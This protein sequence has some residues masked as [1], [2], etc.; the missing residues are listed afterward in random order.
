MKR[1]RLALLI[2]T[3]VAPLIPAHAEDVIGAGDPKVAAVYALGI[4]PTASD[5]DCVQSIELKNPDGSYSAASYSGTHGF[6]QFKDNNGNQIT[7]AILDWKIDS[8]TFGIKV[9]LETPEHIILKEGETVSLRGG[10]LR[11]H[12]YTA[13]PINTFLRIKVRTSW[14]KPMDVQL[15][16]RDSNFIQTKIAGGNLW[17]M[18]GSGLRYSDYAQW[19]NDP[20]QRNYSKQADKEEVLFDIFI[21][22]A[23]SRPGYSYFLPTCA[24]TGYT[25]QSNNTNAT[26]EPMWNRKTQSLEF[27]IYAPHLDINGNLN[28]GYFKLWATDKYLDCKFP[29]NTITKAGS[30]KIEVID[31]NGTQQVATTTVQNKDGVLYV[32]AYGF[33]FS[34]P[35]I[36]LTAVKVTITCTK[37]V[38]V[39]KITGTAPVC[40]KGYK[41]GT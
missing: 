1:F 9:D 40:P 8:L 14:L 10:A 37:G 27:G 28:K 6:A 33:H 5:L 13:D 35:K 4:C 17:T 21:H 11:L 26:G 12:I 3:L 32:F 30:V 19:S 29:G 16:V 2:A 15:K 41:R 36:V 39:K 25:V 22:H 24:D 31:E 20:D 7:S 38:A 18:E 23:D 34:A